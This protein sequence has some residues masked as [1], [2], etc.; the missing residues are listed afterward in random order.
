[1]TVDQPILITPRT[2]IFLFMAVFYS[3]LLVYFLIAMLFPGSIVAKT[4]FDHFMA[5][6]LFLTSVLLMLA[7]GIHTFVCF[8]LKKFIAR[9]WL[10]PKFGNV[11]V[12]EGCISR[13]DLKAA[14]AEQK[15]RLGETLIQGGRLSPEQLE[16]ALRRQKKVSAPLGQLIK[17]LGY[18][19][20][21]DINWALSQMGRKLGEILVE[22][23][24]ITKEDVMWLLDQ[25]KGPMRI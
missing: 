2:S 9:R 1:M 5:N 18:S 13:E 22:K 7:L 23:G 19:T 24:M 12:S 17:E 4:P 25:Q 8:C 11:S 15:R 10:F 3:V 20:E 14:L 6:F 21:E 16:E